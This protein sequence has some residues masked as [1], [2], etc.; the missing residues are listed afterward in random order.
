METIQVKAR[1]LTFPA[2]S[3]GEGPL[4]LCLHGFP[5]CQRS[6][7]LQLPA[8]AAAGYRAVAPALRGY[9][10][11]CQT[12]LSETHA[13]A[14]AED[15]IA[16]ADALT[17]GPAYLVG[18]D[19]GAIATYLAVASAPARFKA[20]VT[21]AVP[22]PLGM[23]H[24]LPKLPKQLRASWYMFFFQLPGIAEQALR[25]RDFALVDKLWRDW[26][27]DFALPAAERDAIAA[28]FREP[29]VV[30]AALAYY[31]ELF[32]VQSATSKRSLALLARPIATPLLALTGAR[33]G[34]ILSEL[35]DHAMG[36]RWLSDC[37]VER[38]EGVGHFL[39][40][41]DPAR[42]NQRLILFLREQS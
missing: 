13:L 5:D 26:S 2:L 20:A 42:I 18:H 19:W 28:T 25:N 41:E 8:L 35:Y 3:C 30:E 27:P 40:Q 1:G 14:A 17:D 38:M 7:R 34:C 36:P 22:H 32:K 33:D 39:H 9:A 4:V 21:M 15:A 24:S 37:T 16:I 12:A 10:P 31:R 6:F 23:A 11:S 29:G